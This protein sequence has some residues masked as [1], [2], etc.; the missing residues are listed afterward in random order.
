MKRTTV[1]MAAVAW[2][3]TDPANGLTQEVADLGSYLFSLGS[4]QSSTI[5]SKAFGVTASYALYFSGKLCGFTWNPDSEAYEKEL[6][7]VDIYLPNR[8]VHLE[9]Q[10]VR[11]GELVFEVNGLGGAS[12]ELTATG[13][14]ITI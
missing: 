8:N 4:T 2:L 9:R 13:V 11:T 5:E 14:S 10:F 6:F 1:G 3:I 7:D 12:S